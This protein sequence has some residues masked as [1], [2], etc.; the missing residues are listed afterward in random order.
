MRAEGEYINVNDLYGSVTNGSGGKAKGMSY[1][2]SKV[3]YAEIDGVVKYDHWITVLEA[4]NTDIPSKGGYVTDLFEVTSYGTDYMGVNHDMAYT[5][6]PTSISANTSTSSKKHSV[7]I[8]QTDTGKSV[9]VTATQAGRVATKTTYK[10]PTVTSTSISTVPASGNVTRKLTVY[11]S[12]VKETTYDNDTTSTETVTGSSTATVTSGSANNSSGAYISSG[13]VYVPSAGTTYYTSQRIAYTISKFTFTANEIS[14]GTVSRTAYVY[15]SA[16]NRTSTTEY[17]VYCGAASPSPLLG[18]GGT[19][20]FSAKCEERFHY[21]YDSEAEEYTEWTYSDAKVTYSN[22]VTKVSSSSF[23]GSATITATVGENPYT[24]SRSPRVTVTAIGGGE[25]DSAWVTQNAISYVFSRSNYTSGT[26]SVAGTS[27]SITLD[28]TSTRDGS[29][30]FFDKTDVEVSISADVSVVPDSYSGNTGLYHVV[31]AMGQNG[32]TA[33]TFTV[34]ITQPTSGKTLTYT[35]NQAAV[36][37]SFPISNVWK[38]PNG[39]Y[40]TSNG[41]YLGQ[42]PTGA[43]TNGRP[44]YHI[45]AVTTKANSQAASIYTNFTYTYNPSDAA[46]NISGSI[47][48]SFSYTAGSTISVNGTSYYGVILVTGLPAISQGTVTSFSVSKT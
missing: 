36:S 46:G 7:T 24:Y 31:V 4:F 15:Q 16:N 8:K 19:F 21:K 30:W 47:N 9:S 32:S 6:D 34:E 12:Q 3:R 39:S 23:T 13:G 35:V 2:N 11:W 26:V 10:T 1:N 5:I 27:S 40:C 14:S 25:P 44:V 38:Y 22:G 29:A 28:I 48:K 17:S 43:T 41:W 45:V 33:R 37:E 20:S 18:T 42:I